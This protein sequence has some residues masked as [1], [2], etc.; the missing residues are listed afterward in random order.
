[1]PADNGDP[2]RLWDMLEAA[3]EVERFTAGV[4]R[5]QYLDERMR[6]RAVERAL[7][8]VGEAARL[9]SE[10]FKQSHAEIPWRSIVGLRNIL[11]HEYGEVKQVRLW[12]VVTKDIPDLIK[13]LVPLV[14]P[15][16]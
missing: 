11:A 2:A 13:R 3:R 16:T 7:E 10:P 6:Q 12:A 8:I 1:M 9:V 15:S 4:S 14:P 5:E